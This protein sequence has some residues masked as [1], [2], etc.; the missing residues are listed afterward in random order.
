MVV[1]VVIG[2]SPR[3]AVYWIACCSRTVAAEA[4]PVLWCALSR[5]EISLPSYR[6]GVPRGHSELMSRETGI[7]WQACGGSVGDGV[8]G[9]RCA[10]GKRSDGMAGERRTDGT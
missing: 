4:K 3:R 5:A 2:C 6:L 7:L 9:M 8:L 10:A 1:I